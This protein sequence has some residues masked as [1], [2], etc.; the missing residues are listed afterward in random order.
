MSRKAILSKCTLRRDFKPR[1]KFSAIA[2]TRAIYMYGHITGIVVLKFL[3]GAFE[4]V[5]G[6]IQTTTF[7]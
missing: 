4:L 5:K 1:W 7:Q 2:K 6:I 3:D